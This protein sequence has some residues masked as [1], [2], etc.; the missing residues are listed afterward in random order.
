VSERPT[1]TSEPEEF[2]MKGILIGKD[3]YVLEKDARAGMQRAMALNGNSTLLALLTGII[4]HWDEFGPE[5][6]LHE[7]IEMAR[8]VI[9]AAS[10]PRR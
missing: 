3:V 1:G 6:G 7:K 4:A 2:R 8:K 5:H 10:T 9:T